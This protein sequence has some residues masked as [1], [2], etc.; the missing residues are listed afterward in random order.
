MDSDGRPRVLVVEDEAVSRLVM[1]R[2]LERLGVAATAVGDGAQA[3]E[4]VRRGG[5]DA[6]LMDRHLPGVDGLRAVR[7]I[8]SLP[9]G[10]DLPVIAMTAGAR[11]EDRRECLD[12]GA[13]DCVA[14]PMELA[15]LRETLRRW[16]PSPANPG[17]RL[18]RNALDSV[19][20]ELDDERLF[21]DLVRTFLAELPRRWDALAAAAGLGDRERLGALAHLLGG[22]AAQVGATRLAA[23]CRQVETGA[24]DLAATVDAIGTECLGLP[25]ALRR[26]CPDLP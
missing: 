19:R 21:A 8:R 18:D 14:K 15:G 2:Q 4:A 13:D 9:D 7:L 20:D 17:P 1:A 24:G 5:F 12:A 23:L 25:S 22:A 11:P 10:G 3:V 6:V 26:A 16:L